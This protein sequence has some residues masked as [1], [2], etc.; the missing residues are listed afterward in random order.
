MAS[1]GRFQ[2]GLGPYGDIGSSPEVKTAYFLFFFFL[3]HFQF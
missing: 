1:D 2:D 3:E